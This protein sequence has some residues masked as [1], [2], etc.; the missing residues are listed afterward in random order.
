MHVYVCD[1]GLCCVFHELRTI[2]NLLLP[3]RMEF[4]LPVDHVMCHAEIDINPSMICT[5]Q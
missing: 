3:F 2:L 5:I 1:M 4:I